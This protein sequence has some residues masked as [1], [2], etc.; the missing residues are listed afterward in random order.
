MSSCKWCRCP[1]KDGDEECRVCKN[2]DAKKKVDRM[3][4]D[5]D[6]KETIYTG[7]R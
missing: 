4:D 2:I 5:D 3:I 1:T 7:K 6:L